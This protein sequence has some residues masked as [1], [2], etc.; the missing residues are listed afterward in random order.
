[1]ET[2]KLKSIFIIITILVC[3][4][5]ICFTTNNTVVATNDN[6]ATN[7]VVTSEGDETQDEQTVNNQTVELEEHTGDYFEV[8]N[9]VNVNKAI[10][11]NAYIMGGNVTISG[12]INGDLYVFASSSVTVDYGSAI[13][14]NVFVISPNLTLDG[15]VYSLYAL[16]DNFVC[17]YNGM[18]ALDLKVYANTIDFSG[19]IERHVYFA[20]S[21]SMT[22][23]EDACILGNLSYSANNVSIHENAT[24][25]GETFASDFTS[26][27]STTPAKMIANYTISFITTLTFL[28]VVLLAI[29]LVKPNII[30]NTSTH[31]T[32]K[33]WK[34]LGLGALAFIVIPILA[35]L[36][37]FIKALSSV[38]LVLGVI[39]FI[40]LVLSSIIVTIGLAKYLD[41]KIEKT[42]SE[43]SIL[44][45]VLI[46]GVALWALAQIP[47]LGILVSLAVCIFGLGTIV[48]S[49]LPHK[50]AN[51]DENKNAKKEDVKE[52]KKENSSQEK[53][54]KEE[55][56]NDNKKEKEDK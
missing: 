19:Y 33:P 6:T 23:Q 48:V 39:Y 17:K 25:K 46:V 3:V 22:L 9:T 11:G 45:Y 37:I 5:T 35:A 40:L 31:L 24:I 27:S 10:D 38:A 29:L 14:G 53:T 52:V 56:N 55:K 34:T 49:L 44:A 13:Y 28:L 15:V 51:K 1:M 36:C 16:T 7:D 47:Y 30:Q 18:A 54:V 12:Q 2:K 43:T 20:A 32:Q 21:D 26:I 41:N 42:H 50:E 4:S 8:G